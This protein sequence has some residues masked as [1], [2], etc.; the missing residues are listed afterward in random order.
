VRKAAALVQ[1]ETMGGRETVKLKVARRCRTPILTEQ[2][3]F[4]IARTQERRNY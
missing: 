1:G 2:E 3:F 4:T